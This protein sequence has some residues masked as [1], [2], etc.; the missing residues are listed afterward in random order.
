MHKI[1]QESAAARMFQPGVK[2][3]VV[4]VILPCQIQERLNFFPRYDS[5]TQI[6]NIRKIFRVLN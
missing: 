4:D 5:K 6:A 2:Y 3:Y 1:N